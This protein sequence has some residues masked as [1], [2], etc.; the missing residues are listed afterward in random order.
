VTKSGSNRFTGDVFEFWRS[1]RFNAT[2]P[3]ASVVNGK[4][5]DDGLNRNQVGG[6]LG[7]PI[8][9]N[10]LFFFGGCQGTLAR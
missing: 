10:K 4:R 6:T 8:V 9:Q 7:G 5:Q 3:F 1:H 2:S